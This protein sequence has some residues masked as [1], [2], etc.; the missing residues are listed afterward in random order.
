MTRFLDV[1]F[2]VL[3]PGVLSVISS[4]LSERCRLGQVRLVAF[5]IGNESQFQLSHYC[6]ANLMGFGPLVLLFMVHVDKY[7]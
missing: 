2:P 5:C 4:P 1:K 3:L 7:M 6:N